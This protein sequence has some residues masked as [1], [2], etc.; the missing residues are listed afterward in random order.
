M[1]ASFL[2]LRM[3][4]GPLANYV[5]RRDP[6]SCCEVHCR[7]GHHKREPQTMLRNL[8]KR[9]CLWRR[10]DSDAAIL[11]S[12]ILLRPAAADSVCCRLHA[13]ETRVLPQFWNHHAICRCGDTHFNHPVRAGHVPAHAH[14]CGQAQPLGHGSPRG[15][16]AI[17]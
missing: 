8:G 17:R 7:P 16:H 9:Q 12:G 3:K 6:A 2:L 11:S 1:C 4:Q 13:E 14:A 5:M 15:M 10:P